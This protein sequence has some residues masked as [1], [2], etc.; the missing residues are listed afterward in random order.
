MLY[1]PFC[2]EEVTGVLRKLKPGKSA[3][4]DKIQPEHLKYGGKDLIIWNQ[5]VSTFA[6]K[7]IPEDIPLYFQ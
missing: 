3:G 1:A 6:E 4:H 5:Q 7:S 2:S